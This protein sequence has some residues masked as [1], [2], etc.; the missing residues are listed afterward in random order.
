MIAVIAERL[1][2]I[3]EKDLT[4]AEREILSMLREQKVVRRFPLPVPTYAVND[5]FFLR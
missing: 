1:C 4:C 3:P 5:N 2:A